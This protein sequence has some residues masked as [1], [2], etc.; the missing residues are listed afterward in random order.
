MNCPNCDKLAAA[1]RRLLDCPDL[2]LDELED[3]TRAAIE[4]GYEALPDTE[5][6]KPNPEP[7]PEQ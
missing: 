3:E 2:N 6:T 5:S 7:E 4:Q 1:M